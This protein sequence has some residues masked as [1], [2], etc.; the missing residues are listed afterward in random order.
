LLARK[1][2]KGNIMERKKRLETFLPISIYLMKGKK[3]E[4][5]MNSHYPLMS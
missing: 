4:M 5:K 2:K 3:R 1:N